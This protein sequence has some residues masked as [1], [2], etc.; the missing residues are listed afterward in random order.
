VVAEAV[1]RQV[2]LEADLVGGCGGVRGVDPIGSDDRLLERP[3]PSLLGVRRAA[4]QIA[5]WDVT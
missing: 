5:G 4:V 3:Y 1:G 2:V